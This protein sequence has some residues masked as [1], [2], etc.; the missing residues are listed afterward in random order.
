M[1][2][3]KFNFKEEE[4]GQ[5]SKKAFKQLLDDGQL[6]KTGDE[7]IW[8]EK[9]MVEIQKLSFRLQNIFAEMGKKE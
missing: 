9:G 3:N 6:E 2:N 7:Y 8:T 4:L 5:L 1:I